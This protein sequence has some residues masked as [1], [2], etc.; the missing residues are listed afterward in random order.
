MSSV[1]SW[2]RRPPNTSAGVRVPRHSAISGARWIALAIVLRETRR[3]LA[4]S[5]WNFSDSVIGRLASS[6][7]RCM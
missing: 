3:I 6:A 2:P 1:I 5:L 4:R 7:C